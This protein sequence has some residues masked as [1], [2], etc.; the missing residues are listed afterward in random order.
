MVVDALR[1]TFE[2]G[3]KLSGDTGIVD[4][5]RRRLKV[6]FIGAGSQFLYQL[7]KDLL[8]LPCPDSEIA[9]VD[10]DKPRLALAVRFCHKL[11]EVMGANWTI[12]ADVD[13]RKVL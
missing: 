12:T 1:Q 10:I 5:I 11:N 8:T 13:R 4:R 2:E 3:S 7:F 9:L 6:V